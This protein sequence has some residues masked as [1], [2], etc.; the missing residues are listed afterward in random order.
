M[1]ASAGSQFTDPRID[2]YLDDLSRALSGA[3]D[4]V[5][6]EVYDEVRQHILDELAE[7]PGDVT[8]V[9]DV[10]DR[11]GDPA[12]IAREAGAY[13]PTAPTSAERGRALDVTA[14]ILLEAGG[15]L[16]LLALFGHGHIPGGEQLAIGV[17]IG[18]GAWLVGLILVL[19]SRRFTTTDKLFG[20]FLIP[21]GFS[22]TLVVL[23]VLG[24]TATSSGSSGGCSSVGGVAVSSNGVSHATKTIV[25][26]TGGTG[27]GTNWVALA[28]VIAV[29]LV[30]IGGPIYTAARL[31]RRIS[32]V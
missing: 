8:A 26:C 11:L 24:G 23:A 10:L 18:V 13:P 20:A 19:I 3:P 27:G 2:R 25:T 31:G 4:A 30:A 17:L 28:I 1:T 16:G 5:R 7:R 15:L 32:D 14:L 9:P 12:E 6:G 29:T 22:G 21:G